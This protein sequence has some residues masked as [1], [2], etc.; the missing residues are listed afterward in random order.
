MA[1]IKGMFA[2]LTQELG[3]DERFIL[4]C[5]DFEKLMYML[6]I[7]TTHMTRHQAPINP[8]YYKRPYGLHTRRVHIANALKTLTTRFQKLTCTDGKLSLLNSATYKLQSF[9]TLHREE[10]VEI[11]VEPNIEPKQKTSGFERFWISY[12]RKRSKGQAEKAWKAL[13]PNEHLQDRLLVALEKAK[14]SA[15]W[16]KDGGRFIPY[17]ATWLNARGWEDDYESG[18]GESTSERIKRI[19]QSAKQVS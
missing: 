8:D 19:A 15:D 1:K 18:H 3:N 7:Y 16:L 17:P 4:Q 13:K 12:P 11:E 14:T 10:E 9:E 2:P 6:V 5:T